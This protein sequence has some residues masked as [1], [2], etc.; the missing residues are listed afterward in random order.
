MAAVIGASMGGVK[1]MTATSGPGFSLKQEN[2]GYAAD[3]RNPLRDRQRDA[4][5]PVHRHAD[6]PSQARHH[7]GALG[8]ATAITRSSCSRRPRCARS[9]TETIRAFDLAETFRTPV[10]VLY[11]QVI[12]QLTEIGRTAGRGQRWR[13][14]QRKWA[15]GPREAFLPY[16]ADA[17]RHSGHGA[18]RR[19]LPR[20]HH[21]PEPRPR[22]AF[23]PRTRRR[24]SRNLGRLLDKIERNRDGIDSYET[25]GMRRCR[26][27]DRRDRHQRPRRC[28]RA[29]S[30][31]ARAGLR[32]GLFRPITLWP[33]PEEALREAAAKARACWFPR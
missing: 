22:T 8:H 7:A 31:A 9:T 30:S 29:S 2:L 25:L 15:S 4:R 20:P 18:A 26:G 17:R 33:F 6:T 1:A 3:D 21:R 23:R 11:D 14:R 19:R 13:T 5:R 12:A 24:S 16:A 32:V 27:R 10:I 28:A